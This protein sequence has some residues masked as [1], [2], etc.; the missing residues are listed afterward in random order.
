M[1]SLLVLCLGNEIISDDRFGPVIAQRL[2]SESEADL[3]ADVIFAPVAG[4]FLLDYMTGRRAVLIVDTIRTGRAEPGTLHTF[5]AGILTPS[6][7]LTTSHQIN[8]PTVMELGKQMGVELPGQVDVI[9]VEALDLETLSEALTAPVQAAVEDT[10][11]YIRRWIATNS[12][13]GN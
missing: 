1:K 8:L 4:F 9:A 3:G 11:N 5:P 10:L 13:G 6:K 2:Q 12:S 7:N